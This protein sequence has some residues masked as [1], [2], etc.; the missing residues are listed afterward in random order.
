M[1]LVCLDARNV[2]VC[3]QQFAFRE[4]ETIHTES[5]R[6]YA[7]DSFG[8]LAT[9]GGWR[10]SRVWKDR[11]DRFA[12]LGLEALATGLGETDSSLGRSAWRQC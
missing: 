3:G 7:L 2:S 11:K 5:S 8:S 10:L 9:I 6:K 12:V 1:H 4:G